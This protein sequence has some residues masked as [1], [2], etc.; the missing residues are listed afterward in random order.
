MFDFW[1]TNTQQEKNKDERDITI[2]DNKGRSLSTERTWAEILASAVASGAFPFGFPPAIVTRYK[3]EYDKGEW[4][5][6]DGNHNLVIPDILNFSYVDGGTF[7]N[8]PIKEAF[9]IGNFIDFQKKDSNLRKK[10]DRLI[11]F[12]DPSVPS[13][14][15]ANQLKSLDPLSE[16]KNFENRKRA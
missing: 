15:K 10:E 6:S 16:I 7:N 9:K 3:E 12:V 14:H 13:G 1:F 11:L 5:N 8:E 4:P 2:P